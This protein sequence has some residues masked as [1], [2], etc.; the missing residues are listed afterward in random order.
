[1]A[2]VVEAVAKRAFRVEGRVAGMVEWRM[3][4]VMGQGK[5]LGQIL[6]QLQDVG[7]GA[8]EF[9]EFDGVGQAVSEVVGKTGREDL[10][11]SFEAAK[12]PRM[13]D[14]VPIALKGIA[15]RVVRLGVTTSAALANRK[16]E[17]FQHLEGRGPTG[18]AVPRGW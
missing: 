8:G 9:G 5:R 1:M 15:V 11:L 12:G 2:I 6:V 7:Q 18:E 17:P 10:C 13:H 3:A 16:S 4:D 14:A